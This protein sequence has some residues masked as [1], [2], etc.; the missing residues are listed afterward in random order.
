MP[1]RLDHAF[2]CEYR[3]SADILADDIWLVHESIVWLPVAAN[4]VFFLRFS[5]SALQTLQII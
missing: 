4:F 3:S 5:T 1:V 2:G